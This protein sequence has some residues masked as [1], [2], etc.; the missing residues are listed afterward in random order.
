MNPSD[1]LAS[2]SIYQAFQEAGGFFGARLKAIG[3]YLEIGP[4]ARIIDIGCGP[5]FIRKY[6]P[7]NVVYDGFD[8]DERYIAFARKRFGHLGGFHCRFFDDAAADAFGPADIV[9]MNGVLHHIDDASLKG[10][11]ASIRRALRPGG[12]LFTLDG[13]YLER[14]SWL[15]RTMLDHDRGKFVRTEPAYRALLEPVF[16]T[17]ESH[18]RNDLSWFP[19]SQLVMLAR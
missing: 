9:M 10:T 8:V 18:V 11:L 12:T 19:Y 4:G 1:I 13:V 16:D 17:V 5:G 6:L 15:R 2:P 7:D 14:Q 3:D